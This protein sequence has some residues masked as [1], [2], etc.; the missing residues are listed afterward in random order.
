MIH[1]V[2]IGENIR[3]RTSLKKHIDLLPDIELLYSADS[4]A[5]PVAITSSIIPHVVIL[6]DAQTK[7]S[8]IEL[9]RTI[10]ER[11]QNAGIIL[12]GIFEEEEPII[13]AIEA[14]ATGFLSKTDSCDRIVEG[15]RN[16]S[17]GEGILSGQVAGKLLQYLSRQGARRK[18]LDDFQLTK[19]EKEMVLLLL[20]GL[21]Y[22]EIAKRCY[23]SM[24][25]LN[26]HILNLY[27]KMKIHSRAEIAA[28][29]RT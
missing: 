27:S 10:R 15:I 24:S 4:M 29:F 17:S 26:S 11:W 3:Y 8:T 1:V 28:R 6:D 16:V 18:S 14:G 22:K 2:F 7:C 20:E 12:L 5:D 25:T 23:I 13:R 19:R 9:V 21:S